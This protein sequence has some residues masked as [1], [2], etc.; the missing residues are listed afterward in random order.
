MGIKVILNNP[1]IYRLFSY[2]L[3]S[4]H[5]KFVERYVRPKKNDII[6]DIGCGP[7]DILKCL[8]EVKYIGFDINQAY[9]DA[10]KRRYNNRGT[11]YCKMVTADAI[12]GVDADIVLAVGVLH[13]LNDQECLDL[14]S[15]AYSSLKKGGRLITLDGCFINGQS[16]L[17]R[18]IVSKDRGK[19]VR[20]QQ[21]YRELAGL[22]FTD[23]AVNV[24][25]DL[26]R[27]PYTH[28]IMECR[29]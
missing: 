6:L 7:A 27:I 11:F 2:I 4:D 17:S 29:K 13:H 12:S 19:F 15:L 18:Y 8:P 21:Q 16:M 28:I 22:I 25:N 26:I 5:S 3:G 14:F 9:I 10:A 1:A 23:V 24:V 20:Q